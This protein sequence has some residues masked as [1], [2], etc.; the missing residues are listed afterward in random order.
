[1]E[2]PF[3]RRKADDSCCIDRGG[4]LFKTRQTGGFFVVRLS[5]FWPPHQQPTNRFLAAVEQEVSP[6]AGREKGG[7]HPRQSRESTK[8]RQK[9]N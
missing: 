1:M 3:N 7:L 4:S 2:F 6:D 8:G 9:E 5:P